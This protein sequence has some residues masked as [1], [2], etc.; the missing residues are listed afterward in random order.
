[1]DDTELFIK[2]ENIR[3]MYCEEKY[4]NDNNYGNCIN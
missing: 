3:G 4:I 1:M 2:D